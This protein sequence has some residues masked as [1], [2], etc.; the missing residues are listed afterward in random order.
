MKNQ[1]LKIEITENIDYFEMLLDKQRNNNGTINAD[2]FDLEKIKYSLEKS[3]DIRKFEIGLYWQR[4]SYILGFISVLAAACA[5]CFSMY[6]SKDTDPIT[7]FILIFIMASI[8]A[9]GYTI[10]MV[11]RRVIKA[12]KYWQNNWE[13]HISILEKNVSGNLHKMHFST[14]E[15]EYTRYSINDIVLSLANRIV[16]IWILI[17]L[18][19]FSFIVYKVLELTMFDKITIPVL[20]LV[21]C[22][23]LGFYLIFEL[24]IVEIQRR[25]DKLRKKTK[26]L[27]SS[28]L[29]ISIDSIKCSKEL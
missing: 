7:H 22:P 6:F 26:N 19:V 24:I 8:S 27:S 4:S 17:F 10:S 13:F 2:S 21:M 3:H 25:K 15:K 20:Y 18:F 16:F 23:V 14:I 11:W 12:S 29:K 5:Y 28:Q 1:S 9:V